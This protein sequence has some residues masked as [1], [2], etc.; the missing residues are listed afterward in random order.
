MMSPSGWNNPDEH[1]T[2]YSVLGSYSPGLLN[3]ESVVYLSGGVRPEFLLDIGE[4][5]EKL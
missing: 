2:E 4:F 1:I 5:I 3:Y